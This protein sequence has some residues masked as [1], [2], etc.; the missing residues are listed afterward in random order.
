MHPSSMSP[1]PSDD[2]QSPPCSLRLLCTNLSPRI[3][4]IQFFVCVEYL[5]LRSPSRVPYTYFLY[6]VLCW[7]SLNTIHPVLAGK[8]ASYYSVK[9]DLYSVKRD[10]LCVPQGGDLHLFPL[11]TKT[12][13]SDTVRYDSYTAIGLFLTLSLS[14][15]LSLSLRSGHL[16][17]ESKKTAITLL[18]AVRTPRERELDLRP[19]RTHK[20]C[21][22]ISKVQNASEFLPKTPVVSMKETY[23]TGCGWEMGNLRKFPLSGS[24]AF[25]RPSQ[26]VSEANSKK[27]A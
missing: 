3:F 25:P 17:T 21:A 14:L 5:F 9:R 22:E 26:R 6:S 1:M 8:A 11:P 4:S 12:P 19:G 27:Q 24:A 2:A 15:S 10:L 13:A 18:S 20:A 23:S 7:V 16:I